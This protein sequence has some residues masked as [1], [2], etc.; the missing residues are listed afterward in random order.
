MPAFSHIC[1]DRLTGLT[2]AFA[3][4]L[5]AF[6]AAPTPARASDDALIKFLLGATAVAI[7]VHSAS[8]SSSQG[9]GP[10]HA[11]A[12]GLPSHCRETLS[13]R[14][15]HV[16]VY[17]ARCLRDAGLRNLPDRCH[18]VIRTNRGNRGVYRAQCL[19]RA[20]A[21]RSHAAPRRHQ[22]A[23]VLPD[24]CRTHYHYRGQRH[25]GYRADCLQGA[26]L[27]SLPST[28]LVLGHGGTLYSGHCL[29]S[30]GFSR[31]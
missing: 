18:E 15:R 9:R 24:W 22:P 20:H 8:R 6:A 28:C 17:N 27:R 11:P 21:G 10:A 4:A 5:A 19:E 30:H 1:R 16:E 25:E 26:R 12:R 29:R 2:A 13:V 3:I 14:G 23:T 7:I 31:H